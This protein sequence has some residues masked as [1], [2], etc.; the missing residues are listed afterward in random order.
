M[1]PVADDA[2][3][4]SAV[5]EACHR[6]Q[7]CRRGGRHAAGPRSVVGRD[8]RARASPSSTPHARPPTN[9]SCSS[10]RRAR[11]ASP[12][13]RC[14]RIADFRSRPRRT[15]SMASTC[16]PSDTMFWIT[17]LGWMMGPWEL[18]GTTLLGA[19]AVLYDGALDYP[20]SNRLW[21]LIEDHRVSV[22]WRVSNAHSHADACARHG[23]GRARSFVAARPRLDRRAMES[24]IRGSGS[25]TRSANASFRSSTIQAALKFQAASSR[26]TC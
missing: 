15:C 16:V 4:H 14:T 12:K 6:R 18:L 22:L 25:S 26:A 11:P 23:S 17:D 24:R 3:R 9:R 1:K 7:A 21:T 20:T 13:V 10:T 8:R 19:T 5:A 2:V